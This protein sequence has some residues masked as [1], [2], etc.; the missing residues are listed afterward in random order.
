VANF[1]GMAKAMP[2]QSSHP[3]KLPADLKLPSV[4]TSC[5]FKA[6]HPFKTFLPI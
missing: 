5:P 2:L 1:N 4:Q 3:F 6:A